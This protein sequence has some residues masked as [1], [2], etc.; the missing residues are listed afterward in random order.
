MKLIPFYLPQYHSIDLNDEVWGKG[1]TEWTNVKRADVLFE[2]HNQPRIPFNKNYYNLLDK[3]TIK[4]Q[5]DLAKNNN[6]Y[7][8]CLYHYWFNGDLLLEKP[9]ELI[10]DNNDLDIKFCIC[11]ANESWTKAWA[12]K[13]VS[14]IKQQSYGDKKDWITHFNYL[15]N[16]FKD[17]RYICIDNK[18]VFVI[19][20][21][22][23]IQCFK[24]MANTFNELAIQNGFSGICFMYQNYTGNSSKKDVKKCFDY[25][26]TYE[27]QYSMIESRSFMKRMLT[28]SFH[29]MN[30]FLEKF[31]LQINRPEG[32]VR[33]DYEKLVNISLK[34]K[35][36]N[37]CI[38]CAFVDWDNTPRR[39]N[40]GSVVVGGGNPTIFDYYLSQ[41]KK[42]I[43][44]KEFQSEYVFVF[45]WNEWGECGY[46]EPDEKN[47]TKLLEVCKK[48]GD[49]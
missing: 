27:P 48:Y 5:I 34:R 31:K 18:P 37:K 10:R 49:L 44:K 40:K 28:K 46:L 45:A 20:K 16:Y 36:T 22:E 47:G 13:S 43:E 7:G 38:P 15:L 21:P 14:V 23:L 25:R 11:W 8:F 6:I 33:Y 42:K 41:I 19:Y 3:D 35:Y 9:V 24:E 17:E 1:F 29:S 39:K 26:I 32:I 30:K 2:G 12:D 4:W